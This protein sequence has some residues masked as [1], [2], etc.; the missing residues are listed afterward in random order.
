MIVQN[1]YAFSIES[2]GSFWN[3]FFKKR[4]Y[5]EQSA[6]FPMSNFSSLCPEDK[7]LPLSGLGATLFPLSKQRVIGSSGDTL[8]TNIW[9]NELAKSCTKFL[10]SCNPSIPRQRRFLSASWHETKRVEFGVPSG[11]LNP[12]IDCQRFT[13]CYTRG[14]ILWEN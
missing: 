3:L 13:V 6:I 12:F 11:S 2:F 1:L 9:G 5:L 4:I 7:C 8:Q 14:N 10:A